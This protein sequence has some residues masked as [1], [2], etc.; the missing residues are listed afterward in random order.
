MYIYM[1][2][3]NHKNY[4]HTNKSWKN[5]FQCV[6]ST[7]PSNLTTFKVMVSTATLGIAISKAMNISYHLSTSPCPV[8]IT[9]FTH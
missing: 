4:K 3:K 8:N 6:R 1:V 9:T 2:N 5:M 7:T